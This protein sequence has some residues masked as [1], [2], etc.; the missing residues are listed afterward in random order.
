MS[1]S[2]TLDTE[3]PAQKW[4]WW[5][6]C[7]ILEN[8]LLW[9]Y[10]FSYLPKVGYIILLSYKVVVTGHG[11]AVLGSIGLIGWMVTFSIP[12]FIIARKASPSKKETI[13]HFLVGSF[14][15]WGLCGIVLL[16]TYVMEAMPPKIH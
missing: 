12:H 3:S 1:T 10:V 2:S 13:K 14:F 15:Y 16:M 8:V 9:A 11:T 5:T 6:N 7:Y 4:E